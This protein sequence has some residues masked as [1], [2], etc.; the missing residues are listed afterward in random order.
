[1][2]LVPRRRLTLVAALVPGLV[3]ALSV[4]Q[5]A[6]PVAPSPPW[7]SRFGVGH[8]LVGR[9]WDVGAARFIDAAA[10]AGRLAL[11]RF[12]LLGERHDNPDHHRLQAWVIRGLVQA[13]RRPAVGFEMLTLDQAPAVARHLAASPRDAAG[14]GGAAGWSRSGWPD[15]ALY[16]PIAE[17]ALDA[18]LP[19]VATNLSATSLQALR[20]EGMAALDAAFVAR[21]GLE[22]PPAPD[23]AAA[24]TA[25]ISEAHCGHAPEAVVAKMIA[26]QR[27][28]DA[29]MAERLLAAVQPD[30]AVLI[31]GAGHVR[32]DW[33]VPV[34]LRSQAPGASV[35]SVAFIE[36]QDAR[37]TL[38]AYADRFGRQ[39]PPFDYVW[40]TP[41]VDEDDPCEKFRKP[42]ER[43]RDR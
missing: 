32:T 30:G 31:A 29:H 27:A 2:M 20:R 7:Q 8:P 18:G 10:L 35:S 22:R 23:V 43:L 14:L 24:M 6:E 36:V 16:Q 3:A 15:W 9:V 11:P 28:R 39:T 41:R 40:F 13:G 19:V 21:H 1:M 12:V 33:G 37:T 38:A 4:G 17:A 26:I 34:Y 5:A 25:E 42:L